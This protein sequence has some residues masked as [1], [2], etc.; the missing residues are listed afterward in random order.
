MG[1]C[2]AAARIGA[3]RSCDHGAS[4]D[5]ACVTGMMIPSLLDTDLYKLTMMQAVL[6]QHPGAQV[7]YRFK[8]RTPGVDLVQHLDAIWAESDRLCDLR[9]CV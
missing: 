8:C 3:R 7:L 5:G 2:S 1:R 6:H 4:P 9:F